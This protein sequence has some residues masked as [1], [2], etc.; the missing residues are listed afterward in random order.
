[1]AAWENWLAVVALVQTVK[2]ATQ[3]T[4]VFDVTSKLLFLHILLIILEHFKCKFLPTAPI[5]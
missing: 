2:S 3:Y 1:M 5:V 4:D